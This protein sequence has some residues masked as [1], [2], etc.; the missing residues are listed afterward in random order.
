MLDPYLSIPV[1]VGEGYTVRIGAGL[2][3]AAGELLRPVLP[4]CRIVLVTDET[5]APL[6][7][8]RVSDSLA[9]AGY[10]PLPCIIPAGEGSKTLAGF[11]ALM[12]RFAALKLDRSSAVLALGGGVTGDLAG[13][14][15]GCYLRG[16]P[17]VQLPTTLLAAVDASVGGKSGVDLPAG[18]NLVGLIL[19]PRAVL[20][21]TDCLKTLKSDE[22]R[23]GLAEAIKTGVLA[24]EAL[25]CLAEQGRDAPME[26][27]IAG[28]VRFKADLV[29]KDPRD[30][31]ERR[32]L[33]LGHTAAHAVERVSGYTIPHGKAVAMGLALTLRAAY[34]LRLCKK[35]C[36]LRVEAALLKAGLATN[37]PYCAKELAEAAL[38]DKKRTGDTIVLALPHAIGDCRLTPWKAS[39]LSVLFNAGLDPVSEEV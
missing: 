23:C 35:E 25:F 10:T 34:R 20:C 17:F 7:L 16:L 38:C 18:K 1:P 28:C 26:A 32:L 2:L 37:C 4:S 14:A 24:G 9:A 22:L 21:D 3:A 19:Q 29:A 36:V 33:N 11:G 6:Y 15:A 5:V 12:E 30:L 13:F 27:L 8:A 31:K 39:E